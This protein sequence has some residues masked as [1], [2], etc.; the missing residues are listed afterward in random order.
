[1]RYLECTFNLDNPGLW[2]RMFMLVYIDDIIC[3]PNGQNSVLKK[4]DKS[5]PL[6][7]DSISE[8]EIYLGAKLKPMPMQHWICTLACCIRPSKYMQEAIKLQEVN[9]RQIA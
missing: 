5:F 7:P 3:I 9:R 4:S 8:P 1:M 6:K 2:Y